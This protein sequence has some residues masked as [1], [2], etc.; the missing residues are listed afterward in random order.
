MGYRPS[1]FANL[2]IRDKAFVIAAIKSKI[3][4]EDKQSKQ[5][6]RKK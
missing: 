1:E 2:P 5:L 6:K 4:A 3:E